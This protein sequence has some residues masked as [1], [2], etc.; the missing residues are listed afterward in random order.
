MTDIFLMITM[1][2]VR[3]PWIG[4]LHDACQML[5]MER[6]NVFLQTY[7]ESFFYYVLNQKK[8][9]WNHDAALFEYTQSGIC[10]WMMKMD[11][12][13]RPALGFGS[14]GRRNSSG[15]SGGK[16]RRRME[17]G[18]GSEVS[19]V[20]SKYISGKDCILYVLNRGQ[21]R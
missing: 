2:E 11:N 1:R 16:K 6:E 5:G 21:L 3:Q 10:S 18:K 15:K 7:Q 8:E 19:G 12:R 9:L 20:D 13:T 4:W 14:T 17:C